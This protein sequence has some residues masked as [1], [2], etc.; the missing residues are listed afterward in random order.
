MDCESGLQTDVTLPNL[1]CCRTT[2]NCIP[3]VCI[4][5]INATSN[6]YDTLPI[7]SSDWHHF[8]SFLL[9]MAVVCLKKHTKDEQENEQDYIL[10]IFI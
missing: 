6:I 10:L 3:V 1:S 4:K 8:F 5:F 9:G 7:G 2:F